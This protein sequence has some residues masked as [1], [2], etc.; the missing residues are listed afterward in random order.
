LNRRGEGRQTGLYILSKHLLKVKKAPKGSSLR[1]KP[2]TLSWGRNQG[3]AGKKRVKRNKAAQRVRNLLKKPDVKKPFG[4]ERKKA[5]KKR[6]KHLLPNH[7]PEGG[8]RKSES[9]RKWSA[10]FGFLKERRVKKACQQRTP[11]EKG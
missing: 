4:R 10:E 1:R 8:L 2:R 5:Q 11:P 9:K 6:I 7:L 3:R